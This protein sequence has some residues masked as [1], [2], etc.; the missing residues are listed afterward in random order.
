MAR[1]TS[2]DC[3]YSNIK[4]KLDNKQFKLIYDCLLEKGSA[5]R[6]EIAHYLKM[7]KSTVSAR[8]NSMLKHGILQEI[9]KRADKISGVTNYVV[10]IN[11]SGQ[12]RLF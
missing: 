10:T 2:I 12:G 4:N 6:G 7:E 1:T 11:E 9:G 5:T 8:V 3:Y